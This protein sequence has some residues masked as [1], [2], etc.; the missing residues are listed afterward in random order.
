MLLLDVQG[1]AGVPTAS[2]FREWVVVSGRQ[3]H[4]GGLPEED[5]VEQQ[6]VGGRG[7]LVP[8]IAIRSQ[9]DDDDGCSCSPRSG[10]KKD[11][12]EEVLDRHAV[13]VGA[14]KEPRCGEWR[15]LAG[16][17]DVE[18]G[19]RH[20]EERLFATLL[21]HGQGGVEGVAQG[22]LQGIECEHM[23]S[24]GMAPWCRDRGTKRSK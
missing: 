21:E 12:S 2:G 19:A 7:Y 17:I 13:E 3:Q 23:D 1:S 4:A 15:D 24:V 5:A 10:L 11:Q 14:C 22:L 16:G 6:A 18:N 8:E 20:R 9:G